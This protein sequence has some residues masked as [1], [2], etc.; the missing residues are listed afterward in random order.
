MAR[1]LLLFFVLLLPAVAT[2]LAGLVRAWRFGGQ[3]DPWTWA[4]PA[5]LMLALMGR[6][7]AR[8]AG[9]L[10][11]W[12]AVGVAGTIML[13]CAMAAGRWPDPLAGHRAGA[14]HLAGG[15][16]QHDAL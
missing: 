9:L 8:S 5:A 1:R 10:L 13:F 15:G 16:G 7:L 14:R 2:L 12:C 4:L 11:M 6:I 3:A